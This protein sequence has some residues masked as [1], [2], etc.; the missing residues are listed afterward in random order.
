MIVADDEYDIPFILADL[1][2]D[3]A[4]KGR[5]NCGIQVKTSGH[6]CAEH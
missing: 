3:F 2:F 1:A 5:I 4:G 6:G